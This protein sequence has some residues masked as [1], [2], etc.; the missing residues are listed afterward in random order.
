MTNKALP[1]SAMIPLSQP[2]VV[3]LELGDS[4]TRA[5]QWNGARL[6]TSTVDHEDTIDGAMGAGARAVAAL[7]P[8]RPFNL[9]IAA[10]RADLCRR[11]LE[12]LVARERLAGAVS[13][14]LITGDGRQAEVEAF[15]EGRVEPTGRFTGLVGA[16]E[17][18]RLR[19]HSRCVIIEKESEIVTR[20]RSRLLAR[21][22]ADGEWMLA[23]FDA[24]VETWRQGDPTGEPRAVE[25]S[26]SIVIA[27][28]RRAGDV[29]ADREVL[30]PQEAEAF[31]SV[32]LLFIDPVIDFAQA[33][34]TGAAERDERGLRRHYAAL[35]EVAARAVRDAGYEQDDAA[36]YRLALI[37]AG[38]SE[39]ATLSMESFDAFDRL[40]ARLRDQPD[41][42]L[43]LVL[44]A[45]IATSKPS[46]AGRTG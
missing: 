13:V 3:G 10:S 2:T 41:T 34:P 5:A 43:R 46:L 28:G 36:L 33:V 31:R 40:G 6:S 18:A 1:L 45:I 17:W 7:Q 37:E 12:A 19:G 8:R 11:D 14:R 29:W 42:S 25:P 32:G 27:V 15:D 16:I 21:R 22:P 20:V 26:D 9:I 39:V 44:R 4:T 24:A 38:Q 35:M 30:V 23:P